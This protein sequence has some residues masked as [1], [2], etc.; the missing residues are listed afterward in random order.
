MSQRKLSTLQR[1]RENALGGVMLQGGMVM[2]LD[3]AATGLSAPAIMCG[4]ICAAGT[5]VLYRSLRTLAV[6]KGHPPWWGVMA[7]LRPFGWL[8]VLTFPDRHR[9]VRGFP[10][11]VRDAA[12]GN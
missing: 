6:E 7:L 12:N 3:F 8:A 9:E 1:A 4:A 10:V 2:A 11:I 5:I